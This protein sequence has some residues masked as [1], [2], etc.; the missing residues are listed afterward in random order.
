M[1]DD[2]AEESGPKK[3]VSMELVQVT[4]V[5]NSN[6]MEPE[7]LRRC[8]SE[9]KQNKLNL[10]VLATDRH[11]M[12]GAMMKKDYADIDHQ[13]DIWHFSKG[14]IKKLT[15]K[16]NL[17]GNADLAPW[18]QSIANHLC[19]Y[20]ATCNRSA[21][22]LK[23]KWISVLNHVSNNHRWTGNVLFHRCDHSKLT[24]KQKKQTLWLDQK[25]EAFKALQ[26]VVMNNR[27]L[28]VLPQLTKF[29]HTGELEVFHSMLLKYCL[30]RQHFHYDAM[31]ARLMLAAMDWNSQTRVELTDDSGNVRESLVWSKRR[32]QWVRRTR[33]YKTSMNH[34][35][36]LI[37][38]VL[39]AKMHKHNL[40]PMERPH[41][42]PKYVA[43]EQKPSLND[44]K[45]KKS[46]FARKAKID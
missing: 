15:A 38:N 26:A 29:C 14:I 19:W 22:L 32:K 9:V 3:I 21:Q 5:K 40:L 6:H 23:E 2:N 10:S 11:L 16:A 39:E 27:V 25:S 42:L 4:E 41:D 36:S 33:Y 45:E 7:G 30:K 37:N 28:N 44:M 13:F 43:K 18:I 12:V 20:A 46:R 24:A 31:K 8:L 35:E 34:V 17:K 1:D